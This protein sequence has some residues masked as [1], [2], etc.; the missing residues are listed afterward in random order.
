MS[1]RFA[2]AASRF[3]EEITDKLVASCI[4]T[5]K[6]RGVPASGIKTV[7]VPGAYEIPWAA[8]EFARSGRFDAVICLGAVLKGRT[9][10]NDHIS[11]AVIDELQRIAVR[12]RVPC[13]LGVITPRTW[14]QAAARTK[15]GM[16]RG[17]E[18]ALA[19][20]EMAA[21]KRRGSL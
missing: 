13:I 1:A 11:R 12:T 19:A 7:R 5:L 21:L 18:S 4:R 14:A 17:K 8:N 2:I 16:D 6:S 10:Q 3:N 9:P 20:L 15:G